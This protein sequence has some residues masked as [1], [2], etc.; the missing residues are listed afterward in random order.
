MKG[1]TMNKKIAI[2]AAAFVAA[3]VGFIWLG[4][5]LTNDLQG[6]FP[7]LPRV[8]LAKAYRRM[9][10]KSMSGQYPD[11]DSMTDEEMDVLFLAEVDAL[12]K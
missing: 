9:L 7:H 12:T 8:V 4:H 2:L 5:T 3:A 1:K 11:L 6:R 10:V